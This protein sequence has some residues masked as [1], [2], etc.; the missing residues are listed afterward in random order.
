M[1]ANADKYHLL[2]GTSE[3]VSVKIENEIIKN[4][5]KNS[6]RQQVNFRTTRENLYKKAGQ[7][8]HA[9]ARITNYMD[10]NKKQHYV[11]IHPFYNSRIAG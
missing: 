3:E 5:L 9:L 6:D 4:S 2:E 11:C 8:L 7:K 10:I 1:V